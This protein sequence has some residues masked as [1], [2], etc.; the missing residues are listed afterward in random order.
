[1]GSDSSEKLMENMVLSEDKGGDRGGIS[2]T[3]RTVQKM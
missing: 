3:N 1:M 2:K